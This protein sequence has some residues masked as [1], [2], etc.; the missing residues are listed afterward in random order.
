[1]SA[2]NAAGVGTL[3]FIL[4]TMASLTTAQY[5]Y[6]S[7]AS[8]ADFECNT[9][10]SNCTVQDRSYNVAGSVQFPSPFTSNTNLSWTTGAVMT[11]PDG[12]TYPNLVKDYYLGIPPDLDLSRECAD[13]W[14][15][16]W[17]TSRG[18]L[19]G[20]VGRVEGSSFPRPNFCAAGRKLGRHPQI[21][22]TCTSTRLQMNT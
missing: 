13:G 5:A 12:P 10:I 9:G 22:P 17:P 7:I 14:M 16:L 3:P 19:L 8:C 4:T 18:P 2:L 1:M 15:C 6:G 21:S 11:Y 20:S